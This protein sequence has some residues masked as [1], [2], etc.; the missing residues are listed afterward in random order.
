MLTRYIRFVT[1]HKWLTLAMLG[2]VTLLAVFSISRGV[3]ASSMG[4]MFLGEH[5]GYP[6]YLERI[7]Q[8]V[9]DEVIVVAFEHPQPLSPGNL[10]KLRTAEATIERLEEVQ[11]V[12]SLLDAQRITFKNGELHVET[13]A[14]TA[15]KRPDL[16]DAL[17]KELAEDPLAEGLVISRDGKHA[18]M[19]VELVPD[20][21][22]PAE[23]G[24]EIAEFVSETLGNA[25][26]ER[27]NLHL[28]GLVA[29][30]S[31]V[32]VQTNK[33]I[34]EIFPIVCLVLLATVFLLFRALW[35]VAITFI[36][37]FVSVVW[38]FGFAIL[39]DRQ[40]SILTAMV[41]A[42][43]LIVATSDVI[44]LC[45]AYLLELGRGRSKTEA[46]TRSGSEVGAACLLTSLTTFIGFLSLS[47]VP[48]PI[49][50]TLGLVLGFGVGMALFLAVTLTPLLL[51]LLPKPKGW[52]KGGYK[53]QDLL[54][55][56]LKSACWLALE[57]PRATVGF[58]VVVIVFSIVGS[59]RV[60][61]ETDL[62]KRMSEDSRLRQDERYFTKHF[63]G[64][65]F[66]DVFLE[67]AEPKGLLDT[68]AFRRIVEF[69][70]RIE[71]LPEVDR[72]FS[73]VDL[74]ERIDTK[75]NPETPPREADEWSRPLLSQYLLLF[76]MAGGEDLDRLIDPEKKTMR[77]A[78]RLSGSAFR[79]S[80]ATGEKIRAIGRENLGPALE[81]E[82][83]GIVYL[84]GN[85]L[86]EIVI[87]QRNGLTFALFVIA[88]M[89]AIGLR[90]IQV[91]LWSM[92]PNIVPLLVLGG[93]LGF[94]WD[95]VDSDTMS[96]GMIAIGIGVDD[97]IHFLMR[98]RLE[99]LKGIGRME[100]L[101]RT[102]DF[103]GRAIVITSVILGLGFA[104]FATSGYYSIWML[105]VLLPMTLFAALLADLL[106]VP[107][108]AQLGWLRFGSGSDARLGNDCENT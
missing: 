86:D 35:P 27:E 34:Y 52:R 69:Q 90:S 33:N 72:V 47:F 22:R 63:A 9:S 54:G 57:H 70:D 56:V 59:L 32:M 101:K 19:I 1:E 82:P 80:Y 6:T 97:T 78:A 8:F 87:G 17:L 24:P 64:E 5:P 48:T 99:S 38:T 26:F 12:D 37:S 79:A 66:L 84:M 13:Y 41:P 30:V 89:M 93:V 67:S 18:A 23:R 74:V 75:I 92:I 102:F 50:R 51:T 40:V 62:S 68:D 106:F 43:M 77:L 55:R 85:W 21:N 58:F 61:I 95:K 39:L 3:I 14:E 73:L 94:F 100:A 28:V 53:V 36:V 7:R 11:R 16:Q 76:E 20:S 108:L 44:H 60:E 25:G 103:S 105:G 104:P 107:A 46:I 71:A 45:S 83:N 31:E 4:Q 65:N 88:V 49:F 81:A 91:G 10:E 98:F 15:Q 29:S 2:F 96:V 42:V